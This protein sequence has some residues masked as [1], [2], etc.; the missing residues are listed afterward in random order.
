M[1]GVNLHQSVVPTEDPSLGITVN[2]HPRHY[3]IAFNLTYCSQQGRIQTVVTSTTLEAISGTRFPAYQYQDH[4]QNRSHR[5]I[6]TIKL[7]AIIF[8]GLAVGR[9]S[10]GALVA[11][12]IVPVDGNMIDKIYTAKLGD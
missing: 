10:G 5:S 4:Q 8:C 1:R 12:I 6:I 9:R 3:P 2:T 7:K 11:L